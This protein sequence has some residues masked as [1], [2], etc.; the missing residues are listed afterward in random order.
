MRPM[1]GIFLWTVLALAAL[2]LAWAIY[3]RLRHGEWRLRLPR[4]ARATDIADE[5]EW[6]PDEIPIRRWLEEADALAAQG[7]YAEAIHHLLFRSI[8]ESRAA[9]PISCARP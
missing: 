7:K 5:D 3:N 6:T 9:A 4:F 2:A 8:E 1:R